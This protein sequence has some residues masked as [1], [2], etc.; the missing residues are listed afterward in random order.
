MSPSARSTIQASTSLKASDGRPPVGRAFAII[1]VLLAAAI[2]VQAVRDRGWQP[3]EPE[4]S[5]LWLRSGE[6]AKR[7]ALGFGTIVS[8]VYWI[9]AVIYYGGRRSAE[10]RRSYD[11]L[12]PLLD[13]ATSLDPR[14]KVAYRFGALFLSEPPP[15]GPG[16]PDQAIALL[17]RGVERDGDWEYYQDIGFVHYWWKH[18]YV[19]AAEWFKKAASRPGAPSWL[20]GLAATTLAV[21]GSRESSR[22]LWTELLNDADAAYIQGQAKHRLL[23]LDAMD[24]IDQLAASLQRF[25]DREGRM[26]RTWQELVTSERLP[27]IPVDPAG[28]PFVVDGVT[29]KIDVSKQSPLWPLPTEPKVGQP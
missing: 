29:G 23:Q 11:A 28:V 17:E 3:Y 22:Q 6:A 27:G 16:R 13:L 18:D 26:P 7:L 10:T 8:D 4:S 24:A 5:V 1:A 12:F 14:F 9:R 15:G 25:K 19:S 21:G 20:I 2:A